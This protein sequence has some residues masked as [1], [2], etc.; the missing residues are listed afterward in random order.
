MTCPDLG[1]IEAAIDQLPSSDQLQLIE[2]LARRI[3]E[4]FAK[5]S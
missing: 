4:R 3:R 1:R 5:H 2:I